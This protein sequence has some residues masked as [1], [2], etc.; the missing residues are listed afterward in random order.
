[1][2]V[3]DGAKLRPTDVIAVA[4]DDEQVALDPAG[5]ARNEAA[6]ATIEALLARG[7]P[8]YGASTGVGAL[9]DR[10]VSDRDREQFQWRLLRSHAVTAGRPLRREQVRAAMVVRANQLAAGGGGVSPAMLDALVTAL[11]SGYTPFARELSSIGTGDLGTLSEI[12]LALLG[13]GKI[14]EDDRPVSAPGLCGGV[15]LGLRD[16]LG[17]ISSNAATIGQAVFVWS[18][19]VQLLDAWLATAALSFEAVCA[20]P[21]VLAAPVQAGSGSP[22]QAAVGERMRELLDGY[23]PPDRGEARPVQDPYPFRVL[24]QVDA[25]AHSALWSLENVL[26]RELGA[27]TENALIDDGR[28]WPNGN[29]YGAELAAVLDALRNALAAS[30][31]LIA[32]R[33]S[34]LL[35]PRFSGLPQFLA[36]EAGLSSGAMIVEY[37]AHAAASEVRSLAASVAVQSV[38]ASMGVESGASLAAISVRRATEQLDA[39]RILVACELVVAVRALRIAGRSPSGSGSARLFAQAG[40]V[41]D[42]NLEDRT[43]SPDIEAARGLLL[44]H[45][46]D[47][48]PV[49]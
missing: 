16:G 9:R 44:R 35:E 12:G 34:A 40:A 15:T 8:L 10:A 36:P 7:E 6:R 30:S 45:R 25:V 39:L 49:A 13:E 3:L 2:I 38:T 33:V 5:R 20:D 37:T 26:V 21:V 43:L 31:S 46:L 22:H 14:W 28:A 23:A 47:P 27:R 29:F 32:I 42:D 48:A 19:A 18:D 4:R 1:V 41:L 24:P 17:F 11:N